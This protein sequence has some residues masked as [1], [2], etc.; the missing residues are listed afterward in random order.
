MAER[1]IRL[2]C[3]SSSSR[4]LMGFLPV[5][6][7]LSLIVSGVPAAS[8]QNIMFYLLFAWLDV[9][10]NGPCQFRQ[11][12]KQGDATQPLV[13][14]EGGRAAHHGSGRNIAMRAALC[15][16][17]DV[18]ANFAMPGHAYLSGQ[19]YILANFSRSGQTDLGAKQGILSDNAVVSHLRQVVHF[20]VAPDT[21][22]A[23]AGPVNAGV[24][25]DLHVVFNGHRAGLGNLVPLAIVVFGK[26][27]S[28]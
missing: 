19:D 28:V 18:I 8:S 10:A 20:G 13:V 4:T 7:R 12:G 17:D 11:F 22:N 5:S 21:G 25:L 6:V 1:R 24:G 9:S 23:Q 15:R 16:H 14:I 3:W 26:A 2:S 27:E